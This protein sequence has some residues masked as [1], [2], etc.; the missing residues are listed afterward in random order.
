MADWREPHGIRPL[1]VQ[2][3]WLNAERRAKPNQLSTKFREERRR[4][5]MGLGIGSN[6]SAGRY[7]CPC[8]LGRVLGYYLAI[9]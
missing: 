3:K 5:E 6:G 9:D 2:S 7:F 4:A 8:R 1:P